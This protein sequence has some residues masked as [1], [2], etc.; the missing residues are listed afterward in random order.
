METRRSGRRADARATGA[1]D[2]RDRRGPRAFTW[3]LRA[4]ALH[5]PRLASTTF[6]LTPPLPIAQ[7]EDGWGHVDIACPPG[8]TVAEVLFASWG[9]WTVECDGGIKCAVGAEDCNGAG[10]NG[11]ASC[12]CPCKGFVS[13]DVCSSCSWS[14]G[15]CSGASAEDFVEKACLGKVGAI[16]NDAICSSRDASRHHY[17]AVPSSNP[18]QNRQNVGRFQ[19]TTETSM[20]AQARATRVQANTS[21]LGLQCAAAQPLAA[22]SFRSGARS[23]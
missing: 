19:Q 17:F 5:H 9:D 16:I 13:T 15:A 7:H 10:C 20:T 11:G 3:G 12:A 6:A 21:T 22:R 4:H 23:F 1:R 8:E 18:N 2:V 14:Q